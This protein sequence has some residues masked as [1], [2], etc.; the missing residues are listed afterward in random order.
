MVCIH[1]VCEA[2]LDVG[3]CVTLCCSVA[4]ISVFGRGS[5]FMRPPVRRYRNVTTRDGVGGS[6][7][8]L[9]LHRCYTFLGKI[10]SRDDGNTNIN[11]G[12]RIK[13]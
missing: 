6:T 8:K 12:Q 2:G 11:Q 13:R 4:L 3:A 1:V 7:E 5:I 10:N 9:D